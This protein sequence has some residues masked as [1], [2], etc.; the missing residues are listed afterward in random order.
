ME[1]IP[2]F[3]G[4][5]M[6][7]VT[8]LIAILML[9]LWNLFG[10]AMSGIQQIS[11]AE[12]TRM[13]NHEKAVVLDVRSADDYAKGHILNALSL[14]ESE[15][16]SRKK[17]LDKLKKQKNIVCSVNDAISQRIVRI[18]KAEGFEQVVSLKGGVAAWQSAN[19]PLISDNS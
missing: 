13:M 17:E 19:L 9:L 7:L 12:A 10:S 16:Q 1:K 14:P 15:I 18:L 4:N 3:I 2:E 6:F 8:L 5:H 11:A